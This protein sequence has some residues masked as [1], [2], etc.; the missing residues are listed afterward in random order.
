[1]IE[2]RQVV[3]QV[4]KEAATTTSGTGCKECLELQKEFDKNPG[5]KPPTNK[6][7]ILAGVTGTTIFLGQQR[8]V[9][10]LRIKLQEV[11][12]SLFLQYACR[13]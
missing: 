7:L 4:K 12:H 13:L 8:F 3:D 11:R 6:G 10:D 1:M 2:C 9:T 5:G